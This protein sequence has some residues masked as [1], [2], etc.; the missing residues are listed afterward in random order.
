MKRE[1]DLGKINISKKT[2]LGNQILFIFFD[3]N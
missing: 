2:R 1:D 3:R